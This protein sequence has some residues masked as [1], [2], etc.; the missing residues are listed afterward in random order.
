MLNAVFAPSKQWFAPKN[1]GVLV[2]AS[3][4]LSRLPEHRPVPSGEVWIILATPC[5]ALSSAWEG[6]CTQAMSM[7]H[8]PESPICAVFLNISRAPV[9]R[10]ETAVTRGAAP[11]DSP[12][13]TKNS[14]VCTAPSV[15]GDHQATERSAM[16]EMRV[17]PSRRSSSLP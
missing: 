7:L 11:I 2:F 3:V 16:L 6:F 1:H 5:R 15:T 12:S 17:G 14:I 10:W 13:G 4:S 8:E 9:K